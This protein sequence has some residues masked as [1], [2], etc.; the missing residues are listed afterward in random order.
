MLCTLICVQNNL[1]CAEFETKVRFE[2]RISSL[3][4]DN[5][6]LRK[7]ADGT[8]E[9]QKAFVITLERQ[10]GEARE[11]MN[12]ERR[13][14]L[15][16]T[17]QL[18]T[19]SNQV[20][21]LRDELSQTEAMLIEAVGKVV[22]LTNHQQGGNGSTLVSG[23]TSEML[24]ETKRQLS[25]ARGE[26]DD[27][28]EQLSVSRQRELQYK[29]MADGLEVS[30]RDQTS[31][32]QAYIASKDVEL[33][34]LMDVK[35]S[36][37]TQLRDV[38]EARVQLT[39]D[40]EQLVAQNEKL[41][42]ELEAGSV[43]RGAWMA[44][45]DQTNSQL[46]SQLL[47]L[48]TQLSDMKTSYAIAVSNEAA[49]RADCQGQAQEAREATSKYER[50]LILHAADVETL[51]AVKLEVEGFNARL[52]DSEGAA[53][54]ARSTLGAV[55]EA[56]AE[57]ERLLKKELVY[58]QERVTGLMTQN[59]ALHEELEKMSEQMLLL[60]TSQ[61]REEARAR[62]LLESEREQPGTASSSSSSNNFQ[63]VI[64]Y[65]RRE[66][67]IAE[68][69]YDNIE[70]ETKRLRHQ[71]VHLKQELEAALEGLAREREASDISVQTTAQHADLMRRIE[72]LN[73]LQDSNKL[74]REDRDR[75]VATL[76]DTQERLG[77]VEAEV[78]PL[79]ESANDLSVQRD[80]LEKEMEILQGEV[81]RWKLRTNQ[82]IEQC[83]KNDPEEFK[84][85]LEERDQ[86]KRQLNSVNDEMRR[87]RGEMSRLTAQHFS[88]LSDTQAELSVCRLAVEGLEAEVSTLKGAAAANEAESD[89]KI[90][91]IAQLRKIG[92]KY[93]LQ[94]EELQK[95]LDQLKASNVEQ[96]Q[97]RQVDIA[98]LQ[99]RL[100]SAEACLAETQANHQAE[101]ERC[102]RVEH[103]AV[104]RLSV[105]KTSE[106]ISREQ[107][108][109]I[110]AERSQL[111][112]D[113]E[114]LVEQCC[115]LTEEARRLTLDVET[116]SA[117]RDKILEE[118][119]EVQAKLQQ[120]RQMMQ[121]AKIK[122]Q[123]QKAELDKASAECEALKRAVESERIER[124]RVSG[125]LEELRRRQTEGVSQSSE[126]TA[127]KLGSMRSQYEGKIA[128]LEREVLEER[129]ART[130]SREMCERMERS[131]AQEQGIRTTS[132]EAVER[133]TRE[134]TELQS[135]VGLLQ[136]Q[137]ENMQR[138]QQQPTVA[139]SGA[140]RT[141]VGST[142]AQPQRRANIRPIAT[143]SAA[144]FRHT[145]P[146]QP[147]RS[148]VVGAGGAEG[149]APTRAGQ[150]THVQPVRT[151]T[152]S[153]GGDDP[154]SRPGTHEPRTCQSTP[155]QAVRISG[156]ESWAEPR[157]TLVQ[158]VRSSSSSV[159]EA[160]VESRAMVASIRPMAATAIQF[161]PMAT[162]MP[163]SMSLQEQEG[164]S[165]APQQPVTPQQSRPTQQ[166][167]P[168]SSHV[169]ESTVS[170]TED[171]W[172]R[173]TDPMQP[174]TSKALT[175]Q[176]QAT[177]SAAAS[178][179]AS[180]SATPNPPGGTVSAK[181]QRD[182][183]RT[184]FQ[185]EALETDSNEAPPKR[186]KIQMSEV[187]DTTNTAATAASNPLSE[188]DR[189]AVSMGQ[190][191]QDGGQVHQDHHHHRRGGETEPVTTS[192][193]SDEL[194]PPRGASM[195]GGVV[196]SDDVIIARKPS[197]PFIGGSV[198]GGVVSDELPDYQEPEAS[199]EFEPTT[200]RQQGG[201]DADEQS[202][203]GSLTTNQYEGADAKPS[204]EGGEAQG[205]V[206]E[207][208]EFTGGMQYEGE[209]E[210][211]E[212]FE[213][214]DMMYTEQVVAADDGEQI[215]CEEQLAQ[216][217]YDA[218]EEEE[219]DNSERYIIEEDIVDNEEDE[220]GEE[221]YQEEEEEEGEVGGT[222][223]EQDI[224]EDLES[225]DEE[226][227]E[228]EEG[229]EREQ[230]QE[231]DDDDAVIIL[232][233]DDDDD[234]VPDALEVV[235]RQPLSRQV[236]RRDYTAGGR[237]ISAALLP[238]G[239]A[240]RLAATTTTT[241]GPHQRSQ[242]TVAGNIVIT[243]PSEPL[244]IGVNLHN[245]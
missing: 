214:D 234:I 114:R 101:V 226:E 38:E 124:E 166:V 153:T 41:Q 83:N 71:T 21:Q 180:A 230:E 140:E 155:L 107:V 157:T 189:E 11:L 142:E 36:V 45:N 241:T 55:Q 74:L 128:R 25:V 104:V 179:S 22:S 43:E 221:G 196:G 131:L 176:Q 3:E 8:D 199:V 161:T 112:A 50:E 13:N 237:P 23:I 146:V 61:E 206:E 34:Q 175:E 130:Q 219:G 108:E 37:E 18:T 87:F 100:R 109:L 20:A 62:D 144:Q 149:L 89:E 28:S 54:V 19:A 178:V 238:T 201:S 24:E 132:T 200:S 172:W 208:E 69:K 88:Q 40:Y 15:R 29:E 102:R 95:E 92:R 32:T 220:E 174:S 224:Y 245:G 56:W 242:A 162:V 78:N 194:P 193:S 72:T 134:R 235:I 188:V 91:T 77:R 117:E 118:R 121:P 232:D 215:N 229:G 167:Q 44:T 169:E 106:Q 216:V 73:L 42:S 86:I 59:N 168:V 110:D 195:V 158:P 85:A 212:G 68:A 192:L 31:V 243:P 244:H 185:D 122:M 138:Q 26:V 76:K 143:P 1:E 156:V 75:A 139:P 236:P 120:T 96:L 222:V 70:A 116:L 203:H 181:R 2:Q 79:R 53:C 9:Q 80:S 204:N 223:E 177:V 81:D 207:E 154:P 165:I 218:D 150:S 17:D 48:D 145:T 51:A 136:R 14:C 99:E 60:R 103:D 137:I 227:E 198:G 197:D 239:E 82:L 66:K 152:T 46:Q 163:T 57:Q 202:N 6:I 135:R 233:D 27:L 141:L 64:R 58:V 119:N 35:L 231:D 16:T 93:R 84:K 225:Q 173:V 213:V 111:A 47:D 228:E 10:L 191:T 127:L 39:W 4:R 209:E 160:R 5:T 151:T 133:L 65:L 123:T 63:E 164:P 210:D 183:G 159:S 129:A 187:S 125:E 12:I 170:S 217:I 67:E 7:L 97:G 30:L 94:A 113:R 240:A 49:A 211:E 33:G 105:A 147:V 171:P 148:S 190:Q 90:K 98:G 205:V 52:A 186:S 184:S 126:E 115:T 182:D